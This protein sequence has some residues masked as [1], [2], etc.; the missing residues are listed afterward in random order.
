M[1][2]VCVAFRLAAAR[3]LAASVTLCRCMHRYMEL[4]LLKQVCTQEVL[5]LLLLL[6]LLKFITTTTAETANTSCVSCQ[7]D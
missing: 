7:C 1:N 2:E 5:S 4:L 3:A 6:L